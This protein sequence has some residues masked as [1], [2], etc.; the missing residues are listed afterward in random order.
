MFLFKGSYSI[1]AT[2][3]FF[4]A[5]VLIGFEHI[6][7]IQHKF[8]DVILLHFL[9]KVQFN[10][11]ESHENVTV[12]VEKW[13]NTFLRPCLKNKIFPYKGLKQHSF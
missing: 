8:A 5:C 4:I 9:G 6:A 11:L 12:T 10:L 2:S 3:V 1:T 7:V 13:Q